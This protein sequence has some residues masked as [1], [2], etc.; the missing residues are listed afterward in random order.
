MKLKS[1]IYSAILGCTAF[2]TTSCSDYL[3][4]SKEMNENLT[5]DKVW[6]N[7]SYTRNWYGN[8]LPTMHPCLALR[9]TML[10]SIVG[11]RSISISV[12]P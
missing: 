9:P 4:V 8:I 1:I 7:P 2:A 6:D 12:R 5:E 10:L 11:L 3:D